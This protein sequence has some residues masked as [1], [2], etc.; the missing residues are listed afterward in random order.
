MGNILSF[1]L[2]SVLWSLTPSLTSR[3]IFPVLDLGH[4]RL[5]FWLRS[6]K[7]SS[8][9]SFFPLMIFAIVLA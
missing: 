4:E 1:T 2:V 7:L 5:L 9:I 6:S 3:L 8:D